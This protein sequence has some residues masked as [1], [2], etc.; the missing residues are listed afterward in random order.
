MCYQLGKRFTPGELAL[1]EN[2][3]DISGNAA[4]LE[5]ALRMF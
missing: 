4:G 1:Q 5:I 2:F 3:F